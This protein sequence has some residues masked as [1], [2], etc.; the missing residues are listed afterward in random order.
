MLKYKEKK[1]LFLLFFLLL[2]MRDILLH[3]FIMGQKI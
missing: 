3:K 1:Q 2:A